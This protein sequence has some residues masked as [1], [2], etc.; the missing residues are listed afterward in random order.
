VQ[1]QIA[2]TGPGQGLSPGHAQ[3]PGVALA[4]SMGRAGHYSAACM[5]VALLGLA[6]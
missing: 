6:R 3:H 5:V 4:L 2:P 1:A